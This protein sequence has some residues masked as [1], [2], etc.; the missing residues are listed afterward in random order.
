MRVHAYFVRCDNDI[1]IIITRRRYRRYSIIIVVVTHDVYTLFKQ[2][3]QRQQCTV[4]TTVYSSRFENKFNSHR[5]CWSAPA[6]RECSV[7]LFTTTPVFD[8]K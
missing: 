6:L 5:F 7:Y 1:I 2:S 3:V 8:R 4:P